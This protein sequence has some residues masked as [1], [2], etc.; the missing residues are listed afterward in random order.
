MQF[1]Y[2]VKKA[3]PLVWYGLKW[4]FPQYTKPAEEVWKRTKSLRKVGKQNDKINRR[5]V[6]LDKALA[7]ISDQVADLHTERSALMNILLKGY[8]L[9]N[10][11][12]KEVEL[13]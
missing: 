6:D 2:G 7:S 3:W 10:L 4:W 13:K 9:Q 12:D 5:I 8:E 1:R 11:G